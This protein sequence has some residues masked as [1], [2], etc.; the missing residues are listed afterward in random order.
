M[1]PTYNSRSEK[2]VHS[3]TPLSVSKFIHMATLRTFDT[4]AYSLNALIMTSG[5][6]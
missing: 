1:Q 3:G 2:D 5:N 4:I 6:E